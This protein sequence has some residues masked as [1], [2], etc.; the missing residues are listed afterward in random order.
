MS[1]PSTFARGISPS[2]IAY[3]SNCRSR[4]PLRL[5][6]S[7]LDYWGTGTFGCGTIIV[8]EKDFIAENVTR[9]PALRSENYNKMMEVPRLRV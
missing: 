8:E 1:R 4:R 3:R 7:N 2:S 6:A 9:T 5:A